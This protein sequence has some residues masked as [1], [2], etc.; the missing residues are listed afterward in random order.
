MKLSVPLRAFVCVLAAVLCLECKLSAGESLNFSR[1][2][3]K[4]GYEQVELRRTDENR[5]F[6][7]AR[8]N[9]RKRSC[10][11]DTG[12]S[13]TTVSTNTAARL[14]NSNIIDRLELDGVWFTNQ[15]VIAQDIRIAGQ[16]A[17]FDVVLGCDFLLA[18]HAILDCENRRLYLRRNAPTIDEATALE[19]LL[20]D[21]SRVSAEMKLRNPPAMTIAACLNGH[22]TEFLV[23]SGAVWSCLDTTIARDFTLRLSPSPNQ[24]S[25]VVTAEK[26]SF[27]VTTVRKFAVGGGEI[28][29]AGLAVLSL[30]PWGFGPD[31]KLFSDVSGILGGAELIANGAMI[32][33]SSRKL[34]LQTS[35]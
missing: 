9:G 19:K 34:W 27:H 5:L 17:S 2:L 6:L 35:R 7:F 1:S 25:G 33:F 3:I 11:V 24:I 26:K 31:G 23:D 21:S 10:L 18:H 20:S 8:V 4:L 22:D 15:S 13:F 14:A 32:D 29:D 16:P 28:Q 30:E 12:W